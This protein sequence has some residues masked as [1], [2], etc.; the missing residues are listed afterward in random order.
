M[1]QQQIEYARLSGIDPPK[2]LL[3]AVAEAQGRLSNIRE[4]LAGLESEKAALETEIRGFVT[5]EAAAV[6]KGDSDSKKLTVKRQKGEQ[7]CAEI[8]LLFGE[9]G[10]LEAAAKTSLEKAEGELACFI[11]DRL[12]ENRFVMK[13]QLERAMEERGRNLN[14]VGQIFSTLP[15]ETSRSRIAVC[16]ICSRDI[17]LFD[18]EI[19]SQPVTAGYFEKLPRLDYPPF[20]PRASIEHFHCPYC[21]KKPWGE[22]DRILTNMG[23][24]YVPEKKEGKKNG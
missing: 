6:V 23:F 8:G 16:E 1:D 17:G 14:Q 21:G 7:R 24:F 11:N 9:V 5:E 13:A 20:N 19:I 15:E 12:T 4:K 3:K 10:K 18:L 2:E 22:H